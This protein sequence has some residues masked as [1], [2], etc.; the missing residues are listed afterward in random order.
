MLI[1]FTVQWGLEVYKS[2]SANRNRI[3]NKI[4]HKLARIAL[5]GG[6]VVG[7]ESNPECNVHLVLLGRA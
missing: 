4:K 2:T 6:T 5:L 3:R 7:W 1:T